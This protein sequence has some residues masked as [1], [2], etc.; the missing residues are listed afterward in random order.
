MSMDNSVTTIAWSLVKVKNTFKVVSECYDSQSDRVSWRLSSTITGVT[1]ENGTYVFNTQMG[2]AYVC[3]KNAEKVTRL[4]LDNLEGIVV[5]PMK[6]WIEQNARIY[7]P[8]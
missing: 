6:D 1:E 8:V 3:R 2:C 4:M 5:I 7:R